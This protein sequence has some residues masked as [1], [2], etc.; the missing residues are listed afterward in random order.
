MNN[1]KKSAKEILQQIS[2]HKQIGE[3]FRAKQKQT[4]QSIKR[5]SQ[6]DYQP[7]ICKDYYE[8][9]YCGY[10]DNCKFIHD[11]SITKSSL[12]LDKE[13]DEKLKRQAEQKIDELY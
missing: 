6:I 4:H 5:T 2:Q 9:G 7:E 8:T 10:G 11:R 12:Q 3:S 13:Y 1:N